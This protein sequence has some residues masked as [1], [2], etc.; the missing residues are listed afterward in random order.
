MYLV[1]NFI[2][3]QREYV[4]GRY[5][6]YVLKKGYEYKDKFSGKCILKGLYYFN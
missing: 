5:G 1:H 3:K 4:Y 2:I 6:T